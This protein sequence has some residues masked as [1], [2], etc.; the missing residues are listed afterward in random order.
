MNL[1]DLI[2][3]LPKPW[4]TLVSE[5]LTTNTVNCN[6]IN[7]NTFNDNPIFNPSTFNGGCG[8][9][10]VPITL[11]VPLS[12]STS[13][14]T[15]ISLPNTDWTLLDCKLTYNG[16]SGHVFY[17]G[18]G[19]GFLT[20]TIGTYDF[21]IAINGVQDNTN[22]NMTSAT[23]TSAVITGQITG[24]RF[25]NSGDYLQVIMSKGSDIGGSPVV[26]VFGMG[27]VLFKVF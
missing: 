25:F 23:T 1:N 13:S 4:L 16:P 11:G 12:G 10:T 24:T 20:D 8:G 27:F 5:N 15:N 18:T 14:T 3:P 26:N 17:Y 2:S 9:F 7:A 6:N 19:A 21:T 22:L